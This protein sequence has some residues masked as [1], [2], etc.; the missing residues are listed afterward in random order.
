MTFCWLSGSLTDPQY[1]DMKSR[2][3]DSKQDGTWQET[4]RDT[5][6]KGLL[7]DVV[8]RQVPLYLKRKPQQP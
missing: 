8:F 7:V 1:T 4:A 3:V 5:S 2:K 6:T